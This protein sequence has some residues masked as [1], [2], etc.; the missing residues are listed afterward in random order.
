MI[1]RTVGVRIELY[2]FLIR[3]LGGNTGS[4]R[5]L[6]GAS[7]S[8]VLSVSSQQRSIQ[9]V[10]AGTCW[11]N[12]FEIIMKRICIG[13][14]MAVCAALMGSSS[15]RRTMAPHERDDGE[16]PRNPYL[17]DSAWPM[18]HLNTY[19]QG[20]ALLPGPERKDR[21]YI[22]FTYL[23]YL[24]IGLLST[25]LDANGHSNLWFHTIVK[26]GKLL[27]TDGG[28]EIV[29]TGTCVVFAGHWLLQRG[30]LTTID[31]V[32][33]CESLHVECLPRSV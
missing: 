6:V 4:I 21:L 7:A 9:L 12:S 13:R 11:H 16:P 15:C 3:C 29:D 22:D 19:N 23:R 17:A 32:F 18:T 8:T 2:E 24:V 26:T 28:T 1:P 10:R 20:R 14:L 33:S 30:I 27:A 25:K 5:G 31:V